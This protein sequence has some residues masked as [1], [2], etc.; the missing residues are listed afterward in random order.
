MVMQIYS[1]FQ[2][3]CKWI[4]NSVTESPE[5]I[6]HNSINIAESTKF[7]S[8]H[9]IMQRAQPEYIWTGNFRCESLLSE[10]AIT[11]TDSAAFRTTASHRAHTNTPHT[12]H[13]HAHTQPQRC[14][15]SQ[16]TSTDTAHRSD[17]FASFPYSHQIDLRRTRIYVTEYIRSFT[18]KQQTDLHTNTEKQQPGQYAFIHT[19]WSQNKCSISEV[20]KTLATRLSQTMK[21]IA[22][23]AQTPSMFLF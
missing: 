22:T 7:S 14:R 5:N 19:H 17:G 10:A 15:H 3:L 2:R 21:T 1:E 6:F 23:V 9:P 12:R 13:T 11:P 4:H 8:F 18:P 16:S 20:Q